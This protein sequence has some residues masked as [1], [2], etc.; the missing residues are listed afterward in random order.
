VNLKEIN[1]E[2]EKI[3]NLHVPSQEK[4][5]RLANLMTLM[6]GKYSIPMQR[7]PEWEKDNRKIIAMY[8]KI[9]ISR[10]E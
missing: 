5:I 8:R 9:S 1:T 3:M 4:A 2:Y 7:K 10:S 6:E